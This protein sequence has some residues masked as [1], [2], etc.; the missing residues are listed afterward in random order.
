MKQVD[1]IYDP[2]CPNVEAAREALLKAF[3][4]LSREPRWMEWDRSDV[5]APEE[6]RACGSPTIWVDGVDVVGRGDDSSV[7][8][9]RLYRDERG[10]LSGVPPVSALIEAF[11]GS[12]DASSQRPDSGDRSLWT[13]LVALPAMGAALIPAGLCPACWPAYLGFLGSLGAGTL[14]ESR[15]L[16]ALT[17]LLLGA[18]LVSLGYRASRRRGYG[19]LV[20][21]AA[22]LALILAA[23]FFT[24]FESGVYAGIF[25]LVAA[26]I[27]NAWPRRS[28]V[29]RRTSCPQCEATS[30]STGWPVR[31]VK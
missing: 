30:L 2:D 27:W 3:A 8:A 20:L 26:S 14:V 24:S 5:D 25:V 4:A 1:L 22:A 10:R 28:P 31:R 29:T 15:N 7:G 18:S 23:K 6:I 17:T 16:F 13:S 21:G 12:P 11:G 19:P 9:C